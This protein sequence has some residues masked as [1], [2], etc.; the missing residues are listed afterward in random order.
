[1][2][3]T[4]EVEYYVHFVNFDKRLDEWVTLD[5]I[6]LESKSS[7]AARGE[8]LS[9]YDDLGDQTDRKITRQVILPTWRQS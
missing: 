3:E 1:M 5:R 7:E 8:T 9:S 4:G 6:N 2:S